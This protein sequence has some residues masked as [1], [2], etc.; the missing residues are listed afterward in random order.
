MPNEST[1]PTPPAPGAPQKLTPAQDAE[2]DY[3]QAQLQTVKNSEAIARAAQK[4][5]YA[6]ALAAE[7]LRETTTAALLQAAQDWRTLSREAITATDAKL[8][9]TGT[10]SLASTTL[11]QTLELIRSKARLKITQN[12]TW[13]EVQ[14]TAFRRRYFVN[15]DLFANEA[16]AG[17]SIQTVIT[18]ATEDK[19]P[20]LTP[21]RLTEAQTALDAFTGKSGPQ[22]DQQSLATQ[23]RG[24]RDAKF[25]DVMNLR[26]EIQY[27]AD[28]A[29]P[30]WG[31][32]NLG[33]RREFQLPA[34]RPL[35]S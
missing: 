28:G 1:P 11:R 18:R 29:Y 3:D 13:T 5:D 23:K 24:A 31:E 35:T 8:A 22:S 6:P 9:A 32:G 10:G 21:Q 19:L 30:W 12:P 7:G 20:G 16:T 4:A 17:A 14:K 27:A 15:E 33:L 25:K 26:H 34:G 2:N